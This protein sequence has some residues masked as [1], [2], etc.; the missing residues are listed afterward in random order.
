MTTTATPDQA[1]TAFLA[2]STLTLEKA[3]S[4]PVGKAF[5]FVIY[6]IKDISFSFYI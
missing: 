1:T 3:I 4:F 2:P 5:N 6:A